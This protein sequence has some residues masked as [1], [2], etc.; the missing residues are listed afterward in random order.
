MISTVHEETWK[1]TESAVF[2]QFFTFLAPW[3][4]YYLS[5]L[6]IYREQRAG[7][8][9]KLI[10][11]K[12]LKDPISAQN[13]WRPPELNSCSLLPDVT[14]SVA[15]MVAWVCK[16]VRRSVRKRGCQQGVCWDVDDMLEN[17]ERNK[18]DKVRHR[19]K[20]V[21]KRFIYCIRQMRLRET[22]GKWSIF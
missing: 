12:T 9:L 1:M 13:T 20:A 2:S 3:L 5:W 4:T 10:F 6:N 18:K 19:E 16:D 22:V 7:M 14:S 8:K 11:R 17:C 15:V 21:K